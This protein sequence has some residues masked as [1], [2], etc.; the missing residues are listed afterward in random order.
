MYI[1]YYRTYQFFYFILIYEN[2]WH[3][4]ITELKARTKF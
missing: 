3:L 1:V 4:L 2:R